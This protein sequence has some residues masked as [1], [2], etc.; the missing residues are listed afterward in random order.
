MRIV[1][2]SSNSLDF[3]IFVHSSYVLVV[4]DAFEVNRIKISELPLLLLTNP[5]DT[6]FVQLLMILNLG[7]TSVFIDNLRVLFLK[8]S[9][10]LFVSVDEPLMNLP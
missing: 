5:V 6:R 10:H 8:F 2:L 1:E 7:D 4:M 9:F 3:S